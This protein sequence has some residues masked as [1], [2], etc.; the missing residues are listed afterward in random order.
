M[1][2]SWFKKEPTSEQVAVIEAEKRLEVARDERKSMLA[3]VLRKIDSLPL[4]EA[5]Q[6]LGTDLRRGND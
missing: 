3:E 2:P 5:L 6:N 1:T 4:E